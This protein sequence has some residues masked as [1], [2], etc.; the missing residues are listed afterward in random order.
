MTKPIRWS[1]LDNA[2]KIFP[3]TS[4]EKETWVFRV[5][6]QLTERVE[7]PLLQRALDQT[8]RQ[9]P[10]YTSVLRKGLFWYYF[11]Q[12]DLRPVVLAE[13]APPCGVLYHPEGDNLLFAVTYFDRRVNLE[14]Y[15]ALSDGTGA[16]AFL[17]TLICT[18]LSIKHRGRLGEEILLPGDTASLEEKEQDSFARYYAKGKT[19][20]LPKASWAYQ[21]KGPCLPHCRMGVVEGVVPV[22]PVL[23]AAKAQGA[24][25]TEW[26]TALLLCAVHQQMPLRDLSRPVVIV[27]PVNLR[28]FFPSETAKNF[29]GTASISYTFSQQGD[30]FEAVL[31][32][33]RAQFKARINESQMAARLRALYAAEDHPLARIVPLKLKNAALKCAEW[34]SG[35]Q[36]TASFSNL[37]RV[38]MP[39]ALA[40]YIER[41]DFFTSTKHFQLCVCSYRDSMTIAFT[42]RLAST[43]IQRHFFRLLA[44]QGIPVALASNL[45]EISPQGKE[46]QA[47]ACV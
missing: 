19:G 29:F 43:G 15:H 42:T 41:F 39:E 1:R 28:R 20:P 38:E 35:K 26:M 14:V 16:L 46:D 4:N 21:L 22:E 40:P 18:Y 27:V 7:P 5:A 10:F 24:T 34:V 12:S 11:E 25:V 30:S 6:C 37:G 23:A 45:T 44:E 3:P 47:H 13:T 36:N 8:V 2:A 17:R 9:F 32:Q 33:V 31:E